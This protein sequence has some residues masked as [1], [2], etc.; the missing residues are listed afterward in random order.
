VLHQNYHVICAKLQEGISLTTHAWGGRLVKN[1]MRAVC[2]TP[3]TVYHQTL[4]LSPPALY[5][6]LPVRMVMSSQRTLYH[7]GAASAVV[8]LQK[9]GESLSQQ[10]GLQGV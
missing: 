6:G 1:G 9:L 10:C 7:A 2:V 5:S 4:P 8:S 3:V